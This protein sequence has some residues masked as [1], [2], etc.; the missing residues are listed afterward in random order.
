MTAPSPAAHGGVAHCTL[1]TGA[2][3]RG[4]ESE[5]DGALLPEASLAL[6]TWALAPGRLSR[7]RATTQKD[8]HSLKEA[9]APLPPPKQTVC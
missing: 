9:L 3:C 6:V 7:A 8:P 1:H 4:R 5:P 2:H